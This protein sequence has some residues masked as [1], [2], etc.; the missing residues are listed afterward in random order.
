MHCKVKKWHLPKQMPFSIYQY[1][2]QSLF[3]SNSNRYS[4]TDHGGAKGAPP[5]A[6]EA[7]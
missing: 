6:E 7:T 5:V 2:L 4:H 1:L 3:N